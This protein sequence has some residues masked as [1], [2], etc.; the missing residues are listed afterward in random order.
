MRIKKEAYEP[1]RIASRMNRGGVFMPSSSRPDGVSFQDMINK[2]EEQIKEDKD[3]M[4]TDAFYE[5]YKIW[6]Y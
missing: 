2:S 6:I 5:K 4:T 3:S 1:R